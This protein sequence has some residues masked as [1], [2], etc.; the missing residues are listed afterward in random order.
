ME[1]R[2]WKE[3]RE[4]GEGGGNGKEWNKNVLFPYRYLTCVGGLEGPIF[5]IDSTPT[6][7]QAKLPLPLAFHLVL[8]NFYIYFYRNKFI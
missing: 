7:Y 6:Q 2:E 4:E 1:G 5:I 8:D 3:G